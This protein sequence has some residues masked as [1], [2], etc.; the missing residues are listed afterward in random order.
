MRS[1]CGNFRKTAAFVLQTSTPEGRRTEVWLEGT[2]FHLP[3]RTGVRKPVETAGVLRDRSVSIM[4]PRLPALS[5]NAHIYD[6]M[7]CMSPLPVGI[8]NPGHFFISSSGTRA[9]SAW[10]VSVAHGPGALFQNE[11]E[12]PRR[13][14]DFHPRLRQF[15]G[16]ALPPPYF[17]LAGIHRLRLVNVSSAPEASVFFWNSGSDSTVP[18]PWLR[19]HAT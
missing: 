13:P 17:S 7:Y 9:Y 15:Q 12:H 2:V 18:S 5:R 11:I 16:H 14:F 8:S 1:E 3:C 4:V 6:V 19:S 10:F